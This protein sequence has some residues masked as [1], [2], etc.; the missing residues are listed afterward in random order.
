MATAGPRAIFP[1]LVRA[2][3]RRTGP[4]EYTACPIV[5][6]TVLDRG[7]LTVELALG[8]FR[9]SR[10]VRVA[11]QRHGFGY[12]RTRVPATHPTASRRDSSLLMPR[13]NHIARSEPDP[14]SHFC[15]FAFSFHRRFHRHF[16]LL[17]TSRA[18]VPL[19][20]DR[21]KA[22]SALEKNVH[23]ESRRTTEQQEVPIPF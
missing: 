7:L 2:E 20:T 10:A 9:M 4:G 8:L 21:E 16:P 18:S 5:E 14:L 19:R 23:P 13:A 3:R 6:Y 17:P 11:S 22:I 1:R 12:A 15:F